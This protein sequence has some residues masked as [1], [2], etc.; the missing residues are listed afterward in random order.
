VNLTV[1]VSTYEWPQALDTVLR[2]LAGQSDGGFDLIV[3]DDGSGPDTEAVVTRWKETFGDRLAHVWQPDDGYRLALLRNRAALAARPGYL[4]FIDGDCVPRRSFVEALRASVEPGWFVAGRR[5]Q[6]SR[7]LTGQIFERGTEIHHWPFWR[8][9]VERP[10]ADLASLTTRDRGTIGRPG[11]PE[12]EPHDRAYGFLLGVH[13]ED[14]ESV[15]GYDTRYVGW[16]E[17]DVDIALRLGRLGLRCGHVGPDAVLFHL[18]HP[19]RIDPAHPNTRLLRET[20][21]EDRV[22]A[23]VGL[24]ELDPARPRSPVP[25]RVLHVPARGRSSVAVAKDPDPGVNLAGFLEG[26]LGL[27]EVAR[28]LGRGLERAGIPFATITYRRIASRQE[29]RVQLQASGE[30]EARFDTN[31]ICLNAD[32]LHT[33]MSDVGA[34]FFS[35]RYSI[36]V[37]FWETN[38]FRPEN[39]AGFRFVDEV[40]VGSEYVRRAV[41]A[42]TET[43][44]L[45]VPLPVEEPPEP[46][47]SRADVGFPSE[48]TFLFT[49]DFVSAE[50]KNPA[51]VVRAF[52]RAFG[53]GEGPVLVLKSINGRER[54]PR[55]LE[56]LESLT[57]GRPDIHIRDGYVAAAEKEA[58]TAA[59]DCFVS[60]HRSEGFGLTMAEA[61]SYGK[62]VIATGYSGNLEFM[63]E[64]NSYLVPYRLTA[65]PADWWAY[66]PG[67]VWA[68]P[69]I[70]AA[71]D[72][73]RRVVDDPEEARA[74][75]ARGR[76][77]MLERLSL[78][79]T[80]DFIS[81]RLDASRTP[82]TGPAVARRPILLASQELAKGVGGS[83]GTGRQRRPTGFARRLLLRALWPQLA[84]Q[85]RFDSEVLDAM[86]RAERR[87]DGIGTEGANPPRAGAVFRGHHGVDLEGG[88]HSSS[89]KGTP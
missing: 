31:L 53:P 64:D 54:K 17:E 76:D 58:L 28:K 22:E 87:D 55:S 70:E 61:M 20:Q 68:D 10:G 4:V 13:A 26:E 23:V 19:S 7:R 11:V 41:S 62:P 89:L 35:G 6:L 63:D 12:F 14:F 47:L 82:G 86:T 15:N 51:A 49:F 8:W 52:K 69:D 21:R 80:A 60:L 39:R 77:E 78:Q 45:V 71:A 2:A 27:G 46:A 56:E 33:F 85:H 37:W 74:R 84:E 43:P 29:H 67:A 81:T 25:R 88:A 9:L 24:R 79:R 57:E 16:G 66:S 44:V 65:V 3:A 18:W 36:G 75:G 40:W 73:M 59:C 50:R 38:L 48:F 42:Q 30:A 32:Y 34:E 83:L 1:I 72:I 5:L